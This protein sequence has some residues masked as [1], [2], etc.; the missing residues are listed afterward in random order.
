VTPLDVEQ[1]QVWDTT[2]NLQDEISAAKP[3][4]SHAESRE[5]EHL[6]TEYRVIFATKANDYGQTDRVYH[7]IDTG[8][9]R[10]ICQPQSFSP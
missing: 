5:L 7:R 9:V 1:P 2:Q 6:Q 8:E 10:P 3:N 4:L